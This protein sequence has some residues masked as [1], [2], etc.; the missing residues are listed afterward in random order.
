MHDIEPW[1]GWRDEY[2]AEEDKK[3]PFHGRK[4]SEFSFSNKVYN[5]LIHPQWDY[6]G[7]ETL[8]AKILF[9]DYRLHFA[10]IE[11]IGEWNDALYNDIMF[12]KTKLADRLTDHK[13]SKFAII[14]ENVMNFHGEDDC[15]YEEWY[16]DIKDDRGWICLLNT[17]EHV[18]VE[19]QKHRLHYYINVGEP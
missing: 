11:L 6:F 7:S 13:I 15:Y 19:M 17:Y 1:W 8:Y 16:D 4:Y 18:S 2:S 5:Y 14:C 3:S 9:V 10:I 12:L